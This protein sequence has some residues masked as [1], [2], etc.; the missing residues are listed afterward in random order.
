MSVREVIVEAYGTDLLF[1]DGPEFDAAILGVAE[2]A[3]GNH[4]VAYDRNKVIEVLCSD[5]ME[6]DE[7]IEYYNFNISCAWV[8][9]NTPVFIEPI[10]TLIY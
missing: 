2:R 5:G 4:A 1:M 3:D 9:P 10:S 8:G 7:A 6:V